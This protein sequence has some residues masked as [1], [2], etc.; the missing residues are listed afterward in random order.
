MKKV[1]LVTILVLFLVGCQLTERKETLQLPEVSFGTKGVELSFQKGI[2]PSEVF[3]DSTFPV[4]VTF[5]N[6]GTKDVEDGVY[7][8]SYE[9]QLLFLQNPFRGNKILL[10]VQ[11]V[12]PFYY[13]F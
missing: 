10:E 8:L 9:R 7:S 3:E 6:L 1:L 13:L 2:T 4:S 11:Q 5:A 12:I